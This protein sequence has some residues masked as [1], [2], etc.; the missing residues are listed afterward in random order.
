MEIPPFWEAEGKSIM[1]SSI[2]LIFVYVREI[3]GDRQSENG[4]VVFPHYQL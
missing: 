3:G 2:F 1:E 4:K